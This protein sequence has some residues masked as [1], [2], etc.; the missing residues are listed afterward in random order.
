VY[1]EH[2]SDASLLTLLL[3]LGPLELANVRKDALFDKR[4]SGFVEVK[5]G[6]LNFEHAS[7]TSLSK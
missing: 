5:T 4:E 2:S 7:L 6:W 3:Q 1:V